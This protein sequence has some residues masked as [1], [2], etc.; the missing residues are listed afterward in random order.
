MPPVPRLARH[1]NGQ[2]DNAKAS[3]PVA[4]SMQTHTHT[5]PLL[6][7]TVKPRRSTYVHASV[8][9]SLTL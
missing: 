3:F 5:C 4:R 7:L 8:V 1:G 6:L 2:N 9:P